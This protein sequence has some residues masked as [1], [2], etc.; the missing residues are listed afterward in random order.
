[1]LLMWDQILQTFRKASKVLQDPEV[2]LETCANLYNSLV[3]FLEN[4]RGDF[5]NLEARGKEKLPNVD[6]KNTRQR[7]RKKMPNDG[8]APE[9][10]LNPREQFKNMSFYSVID[11]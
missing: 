1:M 3:D 2:T 10:S 5:D 8:A 4:L 7:R 6:F 9:V 11:K